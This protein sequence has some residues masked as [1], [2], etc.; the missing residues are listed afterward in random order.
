MRLADRRPQQA[1]FLRLQP[2]HVLI[3]PGAGETLHHVD[4]VRSGF[5]AGGGPRHCAGLQVGIRRRRL[6]VG[7]HAVLGQQRHQR[8]QVARAHAVRDVPAAILGVHDAGRMVR[9]FQRVPAGQA[10]QRHPP[11]HPVHDVEFRVFRHR[12]MHRDRHILALAVAMPGDQRGDDAGGELLAGDVV[13]VPDLRRDRR[14]VVLQGLDRDRSRSSSS[15][16]PS[17]RWIRSEPLKSAHG[18]VVAE[19][20]HPRGDQLGEARIQRGAVKSERGVQ[21]AAG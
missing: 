8:L 14:R 21:G 2:R 15:P 5:V 12:L 4:H 9:H 19:R 18:S 3:R 11:H 10:P 6:Q 13:G 20:R 17:A 16:R 7:L 1:G